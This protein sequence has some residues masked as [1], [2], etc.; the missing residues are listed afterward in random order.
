MFDYVGKRVSGKRSSGAIV[1]DLD[2]SCGVSRNAHLTEIDSLQAVRIEDYIHL[3]EGKVGVSQ[4]GRY[5]ERG[6]KTSMERNDDGFSAVHSIRVWNDIEIAEVLREGRKLAQV[7]RQAIKFELRIDQEFRV[8]RVF[9]V[10]NVGVGLEGKIVQELI[11]PF[12]I[13]G[14]GFIAPEKEVTQNDIVKTGEGVSKLLV[15]IRALLQ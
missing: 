1:V 13:R 15:V 6:V 9:G 4:G 5:I 10:H 11:H 2:E 8:F 14:L 7:W 3:V 12:G